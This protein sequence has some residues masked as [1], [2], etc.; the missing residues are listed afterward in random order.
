MPTA[1]AAK[2]ENI[3]AALREELALTRLEARTAKEIIVKNED[4]VQS[5]NM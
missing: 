1:I 2:G 5:L 4:E 3:A